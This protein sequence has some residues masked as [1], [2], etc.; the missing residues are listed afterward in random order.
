MG[1][2]TLQNLSNTSVPYTVFYLKKIVWLWTISYRAMSR[3]SKHCHAPNGCFLPPTFIHA[4]WHLIVVGKVANGSLTPPPFLIVSVFI[5]FEGE[6]YCLKLHFDFYLK[7][8]KNNKTY[9]IVN[10]HNVLFTDKDS[11]TTQCLSMEIS[12]SC[13]QNWIIIALLTVTAVFVILSIS[14]A[15]VQIFD[16]HVH[17]E[18]IV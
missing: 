15:I 4:L 13:K 7:P 5:H 2:E 8:E 3:L 14:Y 9:M 17:R 6:L 16:K 11:N 1:I 18:D 12:S 10:Y